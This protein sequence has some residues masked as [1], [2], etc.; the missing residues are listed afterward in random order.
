MA[1]EFVDV[2]TER[3][4]GVVVWFDAGKWREERFA[5]S[6]AME[7]PS[8]DDELGGSVESIEMAHGSCIRPLAVDLQVPSLAPLVR[9]TFRSTARAVGALMC[10]G[11]MHVYDGARPLLLY[12]FNLISLY[13]Y[14][15]YQF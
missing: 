7:A 12:S 15:L 13:S 10:F 1:M 14:F 9:G 3:F 2:F 6:F 8:V 11:K 4:R 5:T